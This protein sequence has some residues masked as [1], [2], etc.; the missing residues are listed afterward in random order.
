MVSA[1]AWQTP[2]A[3]AAAFPRTRL[4]DAAI[5]GAQMWAYVA[6]KNPSL[7]A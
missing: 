6:T 2:V 7:E 5:Y 1:L 3:I 4:R